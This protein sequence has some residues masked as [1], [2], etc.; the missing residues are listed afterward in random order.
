M[1]R[2]KNKRRQKAKET[3]VDRFLR[4]TEARKAHNDFRSVGPAVRSIPPIETLYEDGKLTAKQFEAL[5]RYADVA[6][7][8]NRSEVKSNIDFTIYGSGEGL[9]H[10]GVRVN[11]ELS[12]LDQALQHDNLR[13]TVKAICLRE[14][15]LSRWAMERSGSVM[16]ER[17]AKNEKII[18]WYEP[19]RIALMI[20]RAE[21]EAGADKLAKAMRLA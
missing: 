7:A 5:A 15:S 12:Q 2:G 17:Q 14:I 8:A 1:A 10:F 20:A 4:P 21:L 6:H 11:L 9:P 19:K 18:R 3:L 16:R 13:Q